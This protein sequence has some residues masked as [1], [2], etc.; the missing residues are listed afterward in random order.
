MRSKRIAFTTWLNPNELLVFPSCQRYAV[1]LLRYTATSSFRFPVF[2]GAEHLLPRLSCQTARGNRF[3]ATN[4][5]QYTFIAVL[6]RNFLRKVMKPAVHQTPFN[7][8]CLHLAVTDSSI[9]STMGCLFLSF[10]DT[11]L[12]GTDFAC[13]YSAFSSSTGLSVSP[14][15]NVAP[16]TSIASS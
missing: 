5:P 12:R 14:Y 13:P 16:S 9:Q 11:R 8:S 10:E 1:C 15:T 7:H 6:W 4:F 2:V 3:R